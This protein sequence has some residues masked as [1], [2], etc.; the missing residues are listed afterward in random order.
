MN[1][2]LTLSVFLTLF[3]ANALHAQTIDKDYKD[4]AIFINLN[5]TCGDF[6]RAQSIRRNAGEL[7]NYSK[8]VQ[9]FRQ[10]LLKY[11]FQTA[12][13]YF[14]ALASDAFTNTFELQFNM[15]EQVNQ[16]IKDLES[17]ACVRYAERVPLWYTSFRPDDPMFNS[18]YTMNITQAQAA[19]DLHRGAK[20]EVVI[21]VVDDAIR[22]DHEDLRPGLWTNLGEIPGNGIDDDGNG[23]IDDVHG[24][25]VANNTG[26]P[27][28]PTSN[29]GNFGHGTHCA[30]IATAVT[31]NGRGVA[32]LGYDS[33]LMA[34]KAKN[35]NNQGGGIDATGPGIVYA[36]SNKAH[37]LSMSFGGGGNSNTIQNVFNFGRRQGTINIAAAGNDDTNL[38]FYPAGADNVIS[39]ASTDWTDGKSGFSNYGDWIDISAPGSGILSTLAWNNSSYG[40]N[41]GTSMACPNVAGLAGYLY[42]YHPNVT[43]DDVIGCLLGNADN[44]DAQNPAYIGQLGAGRINARRAISC[45]INKP[46][47]VRFGFPRVHYI[48]M[49]ATF[50]NKS[51]NGAY[52]K[53]NIGGEIVNADS[54]QISFDKLG[55]ID[56]ELEI[57]EDVQARS[58]IQI[59]PV[60]PVPYERG[61]VG[62][63]GD[64]EGTLTHFAIE[65][66]AG[67]PLVQ[68]RST[69]N[70]K[71]GAQSGVNAIVL[72]PDTSSYRPNTFANLYT[73]MFDFTE[74]G[75]YEI[76]FY[77]K[78]D[79]GSGL[80]GFHVE[81]T[82]DNGKTWKKLGTEG[83][84]WYNNTNTSLGI[85]AYLL[86]ESYFS[87]RQL[88]Y[89]Q[90]RYNVT[91]EVVGKYAAFRFVFIS[92]HSRNQV[93]FAIDDFE[94]LRYDGD[95][96]TKVNNLT[97]DFDRE[98]RVVLNWRTLPEFQ[99]KRFRV[100]MSTNGRDYQTEGFVGGSG[101]SVS[102]R[103]YR[104][105]T[106]AVR[107]RDLYFYRLYVINENEDGSYQE[108]FY[109]DAIAISRN[110]NDIEVFEHSPNPTSDFV[111]FSF[112]QNL[113]VPLRAYVYNNSGQQLGESTQDAGQ[114]YYQISMRNYPPGHYVIYLL[115]GD[116]PSNRK[117]IKIIKI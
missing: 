99:C 24:F 76:A 74:D 43:A 97:G 53:W 75:L 87:A 117:A 69:F 104:F 66:I 109:T 23:Y 37:V 77:A 35:T 42:S 84:D 46:A 52:S 92:Q 106:Q 50:I 86:S 58:D 80:D 82:T 9:E 49:P 8:E 90:F 98:R 71:S 28:P 101:Y 68:G 54:F 41:S 45:L 67:S 107:N 33:K 78:F 20:R 47:E 21:A 105:T 73:P 27:N 17:C 63:Q 19:W 7:P 32:S 96:R 3:F 113:K 34:I 94:V 14:A 11:G 18:Q 112:T 22:I 91:R 56:V 62:Y 116:S 65:N 57:K 60:L 12:D 2:F 48:H 81:Y 39:V 25:D 59:L 115:Y 10:H 13:N 30:G 5:A 93:G 44:I 29:L 108:N 64:F 61:M 15:A 88:T 16:F 1:R 79:L 70:G 38:I 89:R 83:D 72:A 114:A 55:K 110:F 95:L 103:E 100:E 6:L 26:N 4:G 40:N 36:I 85:S 111:G 31:N 51:L 102:P